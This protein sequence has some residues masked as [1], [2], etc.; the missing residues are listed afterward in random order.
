VTLK[1]A[2]MSVVKSR[3]SVPYGTN[4][5]PLESIQNLFPGLYAPYRKVKHTYP[6]FRQ[7]PLSDIAY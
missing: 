3:P 7:R 5:L 2:E 1:L 6:H 4:L